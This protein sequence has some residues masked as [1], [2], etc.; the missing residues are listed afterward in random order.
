VKN[1][2]AILFPNAMWIT[3][4]ECIITIVLLADN[5]G[6]GKNIVGNDPKIY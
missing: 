1:A 4:P 3:H 5:P 2:A 6:I